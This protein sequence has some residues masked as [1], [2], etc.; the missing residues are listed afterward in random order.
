MRGEAVNSEK[1]RRRAIDPEGFAWAL[2]VR[3]LRCRADCCYRV[4][5]GVSVRKM[6]TLAPNESRSDRTAPWTI[7]RGAKRGGA[8]VLG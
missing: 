4:K 5:G 7:A 3:G 1:G 6:H 8:S 2:G